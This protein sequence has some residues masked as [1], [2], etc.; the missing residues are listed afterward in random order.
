MQF[1]DQVDNI[2][3]GLAVPG[4]LWIELVAKDQS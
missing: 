2:I 4:L 1:G 3:V